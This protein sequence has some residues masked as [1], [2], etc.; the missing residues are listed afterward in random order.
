MP[1]LRVLPFFLILVVGGGLVIGYVTAPG[2]WYAG[3]NKPAFNPP[4]WVFA[5]TWSVLY[6]LIAVAGARVWL[7]G[8]RELAMRLWWLQLVLN[9]AWSP[10]FFSL[11]MIGP[12]L[13]IILL[14]LATVIAF[15][16]ASWRVDRLSA[17]MF[18][19]YAAW[20]LFAGLLNGAILLLN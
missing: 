5:P 9:F 17:L 4:D 13:V 1:L 2:I 6:V 18:L 14:L 15:I 11:H 8:R 3:L 19:P 20:V 16:I 7:R 10:V 12:A